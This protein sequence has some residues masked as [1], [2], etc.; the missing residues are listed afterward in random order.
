MCHAVW[1]TV[2]V[3]SVCAE[4]QCYAENTFEHMR[5]CSVILYY[6]VAEQSQLC[7][8]PLCARTV[9]PPGT[10]VLG[11]CAILL[12]VGETHGGPLAGPFEHGRLIL[13]CAASRTE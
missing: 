4:L 3:R 9:V 13:C 12:Q 5:C 1:I 8:T 2:C 10:T 11:S 7:F 6:N